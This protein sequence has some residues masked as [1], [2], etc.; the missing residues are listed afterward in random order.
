[1][2]RPS[3]VWCYPDGIMSDESLLLIDCPSCETVN[4]VRLDRLGQKAK[5]GR[6]K[7]DLDGAT[8]YSSTPI[9]ISE[10]AFD[11]L[12]RASKLPVLVD[13]W[14]AWCAPCRQ[15]HPILEQLAAE[16]ARRVLIVKVDTEA[17]QLVAGRFGIEAIPTLVLLRSGLEVDR[18]TGLLPLAALRQRLERYT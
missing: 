17:S 2:P 9:P 10:G 18:I 13:F 15:L 7:S 12:V 8:I 6:C 1:M 5:C 14:A 16:M 11:S 4:R 3:V